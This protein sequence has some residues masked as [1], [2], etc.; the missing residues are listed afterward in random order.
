M[1]AGSS[2]GLGKECARVLAKRGAHIVLAARRTE[3]L[4]EVKALILAETP[5]AKVEVMPF[6]LTNLQ[7]IRQFVE[8][9]K[10]KNLPLNIL[11]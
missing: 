5:T 7:S 9:F 3:V 8:D 10:Q 11:M 1:H 2:S 4:N 6:D